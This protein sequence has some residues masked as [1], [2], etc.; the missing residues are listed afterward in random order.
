MVE[1]EQRSNIETEPISNEMC[2]KSCILVSDFAQTLKCDFDN[3]ALERRRTQNN[4]C[5]VNALV[6]VISH[7][8]GCEFL[9][10]SEIREIGV[11][12]STS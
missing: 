4:N 9:R 11:N 7:K 5:C 2:T 12:T 3:V 1:A 8:L 6:F 10:G